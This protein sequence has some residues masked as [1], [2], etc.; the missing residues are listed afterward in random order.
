MALWIKGDK[1]RWVIE[2]AALRSCLTHLKKITF[3]KHKT[4][5]PWTL[6]QAEGQ[7]RLGGSFS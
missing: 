6:K 7:G 5:T 1:A 2:T 4:Q 3:K